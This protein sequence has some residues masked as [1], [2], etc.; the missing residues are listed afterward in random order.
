MKSVESFFSDLEAFG[1]KLGLERV[2]ELFDAFGRPDEGSR[3]VHVAGTNGKGSLCVLLASALSAA[4]IKTGLYT[5]PHLVSVRERF[6]IDGKAISESALSALVADAE[7]ILAAARKRGE[8]PTYFEMTTVMAA[9]WFADNGAEVVV[10]ETGMGGRFDATNAVSPLVSAITPIALD[11]SAHLGGTLAEIAFEKAGIIKP[12][13]PVFADAATPEEALD[14]VAERAA[15]SGAPF[16]PVSPEGR[17]ELLSGVSFGSPF[18]RRAAPLAAAALEWLSGELDFDFESAVSEGFARA[19]WPGR[20]QTLGDGS[21][22]DGA[23]NPAAAAVLA[24]A[25]RVERPGEV[26][27]II[28]ASSFDKDAAKVLE[29]LAPFAVEFIFPR[30]MRSGRK[31]FPADKLLELAARIGVRACFSEDVA[32]A[33]ELRKERPA[34]FAGSLYLAGEALALLEPPENV[35]DVY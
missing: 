22:V 26:F 16:F 30:S 11:H 14:V 32:E 12:G 27:S 23:H 25:L 6:R 1:V 17:S 5:S 21:I 2:G 4:G 8:S 33:A 31:F 29:L 3:F 35:L 18:L 24:D 28:Y 7:P 20:F 34:L 15:E 19:R 9:K 13:V 10:W